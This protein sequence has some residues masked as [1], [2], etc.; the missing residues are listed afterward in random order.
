MAPLSPNK[1]FA[2]STG[3]IGLFRHGTTLW[4]EQK[5]IQGRSD[6]PLSAQGQRNISAWADSL[7]KWNFTRIIASDLGRVR[8]TVGILNSRLK[9]PV[10][11][12]GRLRE[13][14][15]GDWEGL[16]LDD[17]Q[18]RHS[19][20]LE[21]MVG[22]GWDFRPPGGENRKEVLL[23]AMAALKEAIRKW[24]GQNLLTV[25]HQGVIK[26]LICELVGSSFIPEDMPVIAKNSLHLL[27]SAN[28]ILG[29]HRLNIE[30][31]TKK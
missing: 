1:K 18:T 15:W 9:L 19:H 8:E 21:E 2:S 31:E 22:L 11:Y 3:L 4:N 29:C 6:S 5:R 23:R 25:S 26:C 16:L 12:D 17:I 30:L 14:H 24:P 28:G 13:M 27:R 7:R 20:L 10:E